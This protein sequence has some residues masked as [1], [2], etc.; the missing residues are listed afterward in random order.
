MPNTRIDSQ[1]LLGLVPARAGSVRVPDKNIR[2]IAGKS[3]IARAVESALNVLALDDL[4]FSS[5]SPAYLDEARNAGLDEKYLRPANLALPDT[6]TSAVV[7]D[8]LD[9]MDISD[10]LMPTHVVLLQPT[11]PFRTQDTIG[12]A[13]DQ[14]RS[15]GYDS[16]VSVKQAAPK[17]GM[18]ILQHKDGGIHRS[19]ELGYENSFCLDGSIYI[20]PVEMIRNSGQ[21]WSEESTL[22]VTDYPLPYDIDTESDFAAAEALLRQHENI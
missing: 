10:R 4:G 11:S 2:P 9:W 19:Q 20:A 16:L 12:N 13:I 14:W 8:Y 17:P 15:S 7:I 22:F 18:L 5:D 21:F 3:L 1:R 6:T